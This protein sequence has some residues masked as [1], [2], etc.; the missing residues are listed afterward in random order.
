MKNS[1]H[2]QHLSTK[3]TCLLMH[4]TSLAD[5]Q[6]K[7]PIIFI[8]SFKSG[9]GGSTE[10]LKGARRA[11][12]SCCHVAELGISWSAPSAEALW[13]KRRVTG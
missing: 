11:A 4:H 8:D 3:V 12:R 5:A 10:T 9:R 2:T 6:R 1:L 7:H 13:V